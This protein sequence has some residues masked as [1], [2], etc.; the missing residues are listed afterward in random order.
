MRKHTKRRHYTPGHMLIPSQRD[1]IILPVHMALAAMEMGGG[2]IQHRHT[3]AA[4][5]NIAACMCAQMPGVAQE[6]KAAIL[7]GQEA[8]LA[9]DR[10]YLDRGAWGLTGQD[11]QALRKMLTL[12]DELLKRANN[13]ELQRWIAW[14][15]EQNAKSG[16]ATLGCKMRPMEANGQ[17]NGQAAPQRGEGDS[18]G[19]T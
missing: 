17:G 13:A 4:F 16:P 7:A 6:T 12:A 15:Y 19:N 1:Q 8:L 11:M 18:D 3:L 5:S 10:R 2:H 9:T 14:V